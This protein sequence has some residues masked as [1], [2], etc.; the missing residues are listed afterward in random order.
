MKIYLTINCENK[1]LNFEV[2][3]SLN[4][5]VFPTIVQLYFAWHGTPQIPRGKFPQPGPGTSAAHA[6]A[7][8]RGLTIM[9][10]WPRLCSIEGKQNIVMTSWGIYSSRMLGKIG[11]V[12]VNQ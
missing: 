10:V 3:Q 2:C 11:V 4:F 5:S 9:K 1:N 7:F 6:P 8:D 12:L